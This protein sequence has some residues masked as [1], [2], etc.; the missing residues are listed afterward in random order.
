MN[1]TCYEKDQLNKKAKDLATHINEHELSTVMLKV[2]GKVIHTNAIALATTQTAQIQ[3]YLKEFD[4]LS[5]KELGN[6]EIMN[7]IWETVLKLY[8]ET[9]SLTE[10][11]EDGVFYSPKELSQY[12]G[13]SHQ[14][15]NK[16]IN[17]GRFKYISKNKGKHIQI[18][19][20]TIWVSRNGE[21][22]PVKNIVDE[23]NNKHKELSIEEQISEIDKE[24]FAFE[25]K[26]GDTFYNTF[27]ERINKCETLTLR[28]KM[29]V[30][31][32]QYL[33]QM[34]QQLNG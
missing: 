31:T 18:G 21:E 26:Y 34:K 25:E 10:E 15:I 24:I 7:N 8:T 27:G 32:W 11:Y 14:S 4:Q 33:I 19:E 5:E 30:E 1:I 9:A 2:F 20:N 12:F 22:I 16:W 3:K 6:K 13:V 23:Y 28:E 17:T 29:D